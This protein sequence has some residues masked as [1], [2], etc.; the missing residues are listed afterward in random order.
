[1][2]T[3]LSVLLVMC[4]FLVML[5]AQGS[6]EKVD[7][8]KVAD[9]VTKAFNAH[10]AVAVASFYTEDAIMMGSGEPEPIKGRKA[11]EEN[12]VA[13]YRAFPD[14]KIDT[15]R[16]LVS[17]NYIVIEFSF[18]GTNSG[19]L[20]TPE[21]DLPATGR[22]VSV[23]GIMILKTTPEGLIAEDHTYYDTADFMKQLGLLK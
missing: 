5:V 21:G 12:Q 20:K 17:E 1:M 14:V 22:P 7:L 8:K 9:K 4:L 6:G 18:K 15:Y 19:P 2:K 13:W 11:I 23:M 10:D 16:T 3:K